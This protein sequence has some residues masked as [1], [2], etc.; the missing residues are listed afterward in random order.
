MNSDNVEKYIAPVEIRQTSLFGT[1][2]VACFKVEYYESPVTIFVVTFI[3]F[4]NFKN[5][6]HLFKGCVLVN[7]ILLY[8]NLTLGRILQT[9]P[10]CPSS[11]HL[12]FFKAFIP[13]IS[14]KG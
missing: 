2:V 10:K 14:I 3:V 12:S 5:L 6:F 7:L 11:T 4:L 8:T 1:Q 13:H 9:V